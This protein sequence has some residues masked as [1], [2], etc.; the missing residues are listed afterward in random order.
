MICPKYT[1][2][3]ALP[4]AHTSSLPRGLDPSYL[5]MIIG[6]GAKS[7]EKLGFLGGVSKEHS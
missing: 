3:R 1:W 7:E 4:S 6:T 5:H 2:G